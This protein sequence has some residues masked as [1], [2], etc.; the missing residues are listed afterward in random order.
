MN[1]IENR[2]R[3]FAEYG[4][5]LSA[6]PYIEFLRLLKPNSFVLFKTMEDN[7]FADLQEKMALA[8]IANKNPNDILEKE[9]ND[10][11]ETILE[12]ENRTL[13]SFSN[14][15]ISEVA[16]FLSSGLAVIKESEFSIEIDEEDLK[17]AGL[18]KDYLSKLLSSPILNPE[19][20]EINIPNISLNQPTEQLGELLQTLFNADK[21]SLIANE[22]FE[23]NIIKMWFKNQYLMRL[24]RE[25]DNLVN[26]FQLEE[27][28]NIEKIEWQGTQKQLAEL[29][30][31]LNR[32]GFLDEIPTK[33]IQRYFT[34]SDTI[35]Q[36]LKPSQDKRT[37]E[38]TYDGVY[39]SKYKPSFDSIR[40]KVL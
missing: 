15:S 18:D 2:L 26:N 38:N 3:V 9:I 39:S 31:E 25:K 17:Q 13:L 8:V 40:K 24:L 28:L 12:E 33:L 10:C 29:F 36:T 7:N 14:K 1:I 5:Y 30:I 23:L 22:K 21:S 32:K 4:T 19:T 34:K 6:Q 16:D 20:S 35:Q 11:Y 37:K 27:D